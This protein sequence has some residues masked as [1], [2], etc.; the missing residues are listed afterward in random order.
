VRIDPPTLHTTMDDL[1]AHAVKATGRTSYP[2][3]RNVAIDEARKGRAV[4]NM[5][6]QSRC[7]VMVTHALKAVGLGWDDMV[8]VST[9]TTEMVYLKYLNGGAVFSVGSFA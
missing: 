7:Y 6:C 1:Y 9:F 2:I 3:R 4:G 8:H 5:A